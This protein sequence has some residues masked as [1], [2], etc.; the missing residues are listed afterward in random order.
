MIN[1]IADKQYKMIVDYILEDKEFNKIK[2]SVH[3]GTDRL[4][5]SIKVSYYSYLISKKIGL[6]YETTARAGLLH[7]YFLT[8]NDKKMK[9]SAKSLFNHAK[10]ASLNAI[11]NF[12]ISE[13]EKNIIETHMF[14]INI[15]PPKYLEGWVINFVD[16]ALAV[17]EV[18]I[19]F[20]YTAVLWLLFLI[21]IKK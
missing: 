13:K 17:S 9:D 18:S 10:I 21:N 4:E 19:K 12:N 6:D 8:D 2:K 15:K 11:E 7:D 20:K 14:P 16:K 5:H 1:N 3:H